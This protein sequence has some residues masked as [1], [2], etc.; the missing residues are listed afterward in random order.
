M[1]GNAVDAAKVNEYLQVSGN[2]PMGTYVYDC[3]A[4]AVQVRANITKR[5]VKAV[6]AA[7]LTYAPDTCPPDDPDIY[8]GLIAM[9]SRQVESWLR[10]VLMSAVENLWTIESTAKPTLSKQDYALIE[11]EVNAEAAQAGIAQEQLDQLRAAL[12]VLVEKRIKDLAEQKTVR[13]ASY[14]RD[15]LDESKFRDAFKTFLVTLSQYPYAVLQAP[16]KV[17]KPVVVYDETTPNGASVTTV[18][19]LD[20]IAL[21]PISVYW[22]GDGATLQEC[23]Y[24]I[25]DTVTTIN[26]LLDA[27]EAPDSDFNVAEVSEIANTNRAYDINSIPRDEHLTKLRS[28]EPPYMQVA[29]NKR[30]LKMYGLIKG[31]LLA[32]FIPSERL[33]D[34]QLDP[35][36]YYEAEVWVIDGLCVMSKLS[37]APL[38]KR[39][40]YS[41][42]LYSKPNSIVGNGMAD[43]I[44][45]VERVVNSSNRQILLNL[46]LASRPILEVQR[47]RITNIKP[48]EGI[49]IHPGMVIETETSLMSDGSPVVT[50][51]NVS[52]NVQEF[53]RVKQ[54]AISQA[55]V[56]SG[57]PAHI[58]GTLD[59]ASMARTEGGLA[60]LMK[61]ATLLMQNMI[62]NIDSDI[63]SPMLENLYNTIMLYSSDPE[64]KADASIK[65]KGV[66]GVLQTEVGQAKLQTLLTIISPYAN[67][68]IVPPQLLVNLLRQIII[69]LGYDADKIVPANMA[70]AAIEFQ[71]TLSAARI[72]GLTPEPQAKGSPAVGG[73]VGK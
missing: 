48:E 26:Y 51:H 56:L 66:S 45:D 4:K 27:I 23:S 49:I 14:V 39:G 55:D 34:T 42:S 46:P 72:T 65:A 20:V 62:A 7:N 32:A 5:L 35:A 12:R 41:T 67:S 19:K 59:V 11:T 50:L 71:S 15:I 25:V 16:V 52:S 8:S 29:G 30:V 61:A 9:K 63:L 70:S 64:I 2:D 57:V 60:M 28:G 31:A 73:A 33:G 38:G 47:D 68:G 6:Y 3:F 22:S 69:D 21:D 58:A 17:V 44:G 1:I 18:N 24:V 53:M 43:V 54:D 37:D 36:R 13:L 10:S 40:I